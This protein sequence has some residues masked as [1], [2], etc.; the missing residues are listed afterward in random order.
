MHRRI[1]GHRQSLV[2]MLQLNVV[3]GG[4]ARSMIDN[5]SETTLART[6][7]PTFTPSSTDTRTSRPFRISAMELC[8]MFLTASPPTCLP[9]PPSS[10]EQ[11]VKAN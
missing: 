3:T 1:A 9:L 10:L 11:V 2:R 8:W 6:T 7:R 4:Q 5:M